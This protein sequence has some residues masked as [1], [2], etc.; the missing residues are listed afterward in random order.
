VRR[1]DITDCIK[2]GKDFADNDFADC[3]V[4]EF[5]KPFAQYRLDVG[6]AHK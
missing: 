5:S 4:R 1:A 3:R 2:M 6:A